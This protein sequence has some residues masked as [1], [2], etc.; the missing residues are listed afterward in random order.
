MS[1]ILDALR[2]MEQERRTRRQGGADIRADVLNYQGRTAP[3]KKSRQFAPIG[4][5]G[6][7]LVVTAGALVIIFRQE[8]STRGV[9]Q[10]SP[11]VAIGRPAAKQ[12]VAMPAPLPGGQAVPLPK[13]DA[14]ATVPVPPPA[15][16]SADHGE[17][18]VISGIAW[19]EERGLR[20]AVVNGALA[21][22]GAE[23]LGASIVEIREDRVIF[24]RNGR[25]FEIPYAGGGGRQ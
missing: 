18:L 9:E 20:R 19:Q 24:S 16:T 4:L 17:T 13:P 7:S 6:L 22:E 14:A 11:A 15:I 8:L 3:V 5:L 21:G 10:G 25:S 23:V 1:L 12:P 2:K